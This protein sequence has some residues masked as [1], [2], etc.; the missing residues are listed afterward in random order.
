MC[1]QINDLLKNNLIWFPEK[2]VGYYPVKEGK[3]LKNYFIEY[4]NLASSTKGELIT[5][6]RV[7]LVRKYYDGLVVDVGIGSGHF[8]ERHGNATGFDVNSDAVNWLKEKNRYCNL[9][10]GEHIAATFWDSLEHIKE[11]NVALRH[12]KKWVFI[13]IPI[14]TD[15]N[16]ILKSKHYKKDE[17]Y[18]YFT[19]A[20]LVDWFYEQGF[21]I[22]DHNDMETQ[23]GRESIGTY[24][25]KKIGA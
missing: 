1:R 4:G 22:I 7:N 16:N 25:L 20:G 5:Q 12:V 17:H 8:I 21:E 19:H 23:L 24:V 2:G 11:P 15:I 18:W 9:Y 14:F 3:C 13:S 6:V 10:E